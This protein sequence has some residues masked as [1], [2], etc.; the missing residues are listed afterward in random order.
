ME[1]YN[2]SYDAYRDLVKNIDV[3]YQHLYYVIKPI[4]ILSLYCFLLNLCPEVFIFNYID[5]LKSQYKNNPYFYR[6]WC[7]LNCC[8]IHRN[9]K[10][11][12]LFFESIYFKLKQIPYTSN[13]LII[14]KFKTIQKSPRVSFLLVYELSY[15]ATR[16]I[17]FIDYTI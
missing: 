10:L 13:K 7:I 4:L 9:W 11:K 16:N 5:E 1:K 14:Q 3:I 17:W 12:C 2:E 6:I 15:S 8:K